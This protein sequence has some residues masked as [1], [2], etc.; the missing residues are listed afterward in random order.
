[1]AQPYQLVVDLG[2]CHT[3]AVVRRAGEAPRPL[4][5]DGSPLLP[6]GIYRAE[7]GRLTVG[8]DAER[9]AATAPSRF[10]P[11]PKRTVDDGSVL[12]GDAAVPV[13]ELLAAILR[14]VIVEAAQQGV[15]P[16]V[17][18]L[19]APADWGPRRREVLLAAARTAG[20]PQVRL[21]DEP[22]AA[23]TYCV[24]VLGQQIPPGRCLLVFDF[25]GGTLDVTVVRREA[26]GL[27]VLAVGGLDDLGGVDVD[28]ALVGHLGQLISLRAPQ[29]WQRLVRPQ[30]TG[31]L[32]DR[33]AFWDQVRGAKEMLSR[34]P[35]A[36]V[37]LPGSDD[38]VHLTREELERVAG[39]LVDRAVDETR[40]VL[41]RAGVVPGSMAGILLVGGSSRIP[42]VASRLHARFGVAPT[43]PEQPELPVAYGGLLVD[44]PTVAP[45]P[46][47][48]TPAPQWTP[49]PVPAPQPGTPRRRRPV[50]TAVIVLVVLAVVGALSW[51]GAYAAKSISNAVRHGTPGPSAGT[52]GGVAGGSGGKLTSVS[53]YPQPLPD[54][55]VAGMTVGGDAVFT[56]VTKSGHTEVTAVALPGTE[57]PHWSNAKV[58]VDPAKIVMNVVHG[59]LILDVDKSNTDKG[60]DVRAVLDVTNGRYLW[61]KAW[62]HSDSTDL[63]YIGTDVIVARQFDTLTER[64]DLRTGSTK[65]TH[66]APSDVANAWHHAKAAL[67]WQTAVGASTAPVPRT[68]SAFQES[69]VADATKVVQV[70]EDTGTAEILNAA[71]GRR[72]VA[73]PVSLADDLID[74]TWT[75]YDGLV[76]GAAKDG[77]AALNAYRTSN[78]KQAWRFP[79]PAGADVKLVKGC[80]PRLV[81]ASIEVGSEYRVLAVD[82]KNGKAGWGT[83][84]LKPGDEPGWY[85]LD[86]RVVYGGL[87]FVS[88]GSSRLPASLLDDKG[89]TS[90][91]VSGDYTS[92]NAAGGRYGALVRPQYGS[93]SHWGVSIVDLETGKQTVWQD[94]GPVNGQPTISVTGTTVAAINGGQLY[95]L[96]APGL[97]AR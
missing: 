13:V 85:V 65:W 60:N 72:I 58:P 49:P 19:T 48:W 16:G 73:Q 6:S 97:A 88:V 7:D 79:L 28:A 29:V 92:M 83:T 3:V 24:E 33:K 4:L 15:D 90:K 61:K 12:L 77:G 21:V 82:T 18:T 69:F 41:E 62:S 39:P 35:S 95:L 86:Q 55:A 9:L 74:V 2:T 67:T 81:C 59:L 94:I 50:R 38:A 70:Y 5:F 11:Y 40:R 64:V 75:A 91:L 80:G 36:P 93:T 25:G 46:P 31:D 17:I 89:V 87:S 26:Q 63:A 57:G 20:M 8:R 52:V 84:V 54:G 37:P 51:G 30:G 47:Q 32:R 96:Q 14:R 71:T 76:I 27:R 53:G 42:L 10:E 34:A 22:I 44:T 23:A 45:P 1:V 66:P 78:L 56:A 43:V 68:A